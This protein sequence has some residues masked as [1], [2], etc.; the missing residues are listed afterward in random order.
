MAHN[1]TVR[2]DK[3]Q[4]CVIG[5]SVLGRKPCVHS[6]LGM[7]I[8]LCV[9]EIFMADPT[10]I[11]A[12]FI[13]PWALSAYKCL[14]V[15]GTN[16]MHLYTYALMNI[17]E[18]KFHTVLVLVSHVLCSI[19]VT[20]RLVSPNGVFRTVSLDGPSGTSGARNEYDAH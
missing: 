13:S 6:Y 4:S 20:Y 19:F 2:G 3:M 16:V 12:V 11:Y 9:D 18:A 7:L 5:T 17:I 1:C 8:M 14:I 15:M 10:V